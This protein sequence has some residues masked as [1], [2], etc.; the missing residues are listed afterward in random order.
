MAA[1]EPEYSAMSGW[2]RGIGRDGIGDS[3]TFVLR[4]TVES[5]EGGPATW[6]RL[7]EAGSGTVT[8]FNDVSAALQAL[9]DRLS[10]IVARSKGQE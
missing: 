1:H 8:H 5:R 2:P 3:H 4:I 9:S 10:V 7:E 6:L